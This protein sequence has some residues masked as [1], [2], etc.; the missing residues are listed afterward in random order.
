MDKKKDNEAEIKTQKTHSNVT[1][2]QTNECVAYISRIIHK[3]LCS[4]K[5]PY[6]SSQKSFAKGCNR[7][8]LSG[9]FWCC[10][11][12]YVRKQLNIVYV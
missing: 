3:H 4:D 12:I 8:A 2:I 9:L 1:K 11:D 7:S 10:V 6:P 5:K